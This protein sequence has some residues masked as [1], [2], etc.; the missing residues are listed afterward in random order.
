MTA[1]SAHELAPASTSWSRIYAP[2]NRSVEQATVGHFALIPT[3][4][5]VE[6]PARRQ[7]DG[8]K[9]RSLGT[10]PLRPRERARLARIERELV[11]LHIDQHRPRRRSDC[12]PDD[13]PCP[14]VSCRHHLALEVEQR[15]GLKPAV[16]LMF[17]DRQLAEMAETCSLRVARRQEALRETLTTEQVGALMNLT[18]ERVRQDEQRALRKVRAALAAAL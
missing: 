1:A 5:L 16:K 3:R 7:R 15:P 8:V 13:S 6:G 11:A 4:R 14:F 17:P 12:P 9:P 18:A 2:D 10:E